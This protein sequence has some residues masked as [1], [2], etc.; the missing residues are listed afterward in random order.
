MPVDEHTLVAI[1]DRIYQLA[2]TRRR[3][4]A[5]AIDL[6]LLVTCENF[7]AAPL[8]SLL[9]A[10]LQTGAWIAYYMMAIF[11]LLLGDTWLQGASF[12]KQLAGLRVVRLDSGRPPTAKESLMRSIDSARLL[13]VP[14][15][16]F[17]AIE[18]PDCAIAGRF[19]VV[20]A[21]PYEPPAQLNTQVFGP[22]PGRVNMDDLGDF[23]AK[24]FGQKTEEPKE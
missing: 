22:P 13:T 17:A 7:V 3:F 5:R 2:P 18:G 6:G 8:F 23:L 21:K 19:A 20:R 16:L 14:G 1:G 12:G 24:K 10:P 15:V 9:P 4:G 11:Y